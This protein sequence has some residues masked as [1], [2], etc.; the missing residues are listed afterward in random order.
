MFHRLNN[1]V[2]IVFRSSPWKF[3]ERDYQTPVLRCHMYLVHMASFLSR[4]IHADG[5]V[6]CAIQDFR[7]LQVT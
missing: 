4:G 2:C 6:V 5:N 1:M 7:D 3:V